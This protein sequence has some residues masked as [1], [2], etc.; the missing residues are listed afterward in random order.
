MTNS[1]NIRIYKVTV[2]VQT[3]EG[4]NINVPR[5][6]RFQDEADKFYRSAHAA[7]GNVNSIGEKIVAVHA[8][9]LR[10]FLYGRADDAISGFH[11]FGCK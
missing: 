2:V 10:E 4:E 5:R 7:I 11:S 1:A 6:F 3:P 9:F 8:G